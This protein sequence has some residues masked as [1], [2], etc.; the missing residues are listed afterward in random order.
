MLRDVDANKRVCLILFA[1]TN[2]F[3]S[4][5]RRGKKKKGFAGLCRAVCTAGVECVRQGARRDC[6]SW[7]LG[8]GFV[9][10]LLMRVVTAVFV[11]T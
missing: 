7:A 5:F 6:L 2:R 3:V 1:D 11:S 9:R 4:V 8:K 10:S